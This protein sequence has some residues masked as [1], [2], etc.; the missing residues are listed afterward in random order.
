MAEKLCQ[1]FPQGE[2]KIV[3]VEKSVKETGILKISS[4]KAKNILGW[5]PKYTIDD[6]LRM[7][8]EFAIREHQGEPA[9][10]ICMEY[11]DE[12]WKQR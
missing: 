5:N 2:V 11:I 8:A 10:E 6:T 7:A 12:Y 4:N 1:Y 3:S 9:R